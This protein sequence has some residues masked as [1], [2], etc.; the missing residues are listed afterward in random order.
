M[1]SVTA[2][3]CALLTAAHLVNAAPA[4]QAATTPVVSTGTTEQPIP[5][6]YDQKYDVGT[7]SLNTVACSDGTNGLE[8]DDYTTFGSLPTFPMIGGA[9]TIDGWN[10]SACGTCYQ[11]H[12]QSGKIDET[13]NILAIDAA[14]GGFNI[15]LT[16]MNRLTNGQA[17]NLGRVTATYVE[18]DGS[19]C[20]ISSEN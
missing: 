12:F 10:S 9:P 15:G 2:I 14:S 18:V 4:P 7:S 19:V 13:I 17:E 3:T 1:K 5:V 16:A 20:G 11:L 6:S 8:S